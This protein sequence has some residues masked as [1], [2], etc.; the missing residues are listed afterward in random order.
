MKYLVLAGHD[1]AELVGGDVDHRAA[2]TDDHVP[3]ARWR[4]RQ[5]RLVQRHPT[6]GSQRLQTL[7]THTHTHT[8]I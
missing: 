6:T 8:H 1:V 7:R 2:P 3:S 5:R 4:Q